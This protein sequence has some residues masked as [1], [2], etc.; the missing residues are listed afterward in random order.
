[1][2][3]LVSSV[4][5]L[6]LFCSA[7]YASGQ[8][9]LHRNHSD[10]A[11]RI[12]PSTMCGRVLWPRT[13]RRR[14][15]WLKLQSAPVLIRARSSRAKLRTNIFLRGSEL[16]VPFW[17]ASS[18]PCLVL[19]WRQLRR[20]ICVSQNQGNA[21]SQKRTGPYDAR[22]PRAYRSLRTAVALFR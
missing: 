19:S 11:C 9:D 12:T 14:K 6:G 18:Y 17:L 16:D 1:M 5:L 8:P 4:S 7:L 20:G 10:D 22:R 15:C 3:R 13:G 21:V 2:P